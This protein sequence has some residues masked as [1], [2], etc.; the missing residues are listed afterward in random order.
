MKVGDV[1]FRKYRTQQNPSPTRE[2]KDWT[3]IVISLFEKKVW[4]TQELGPIVNWD[5]IDSE[6]HA[7]VLINERVVS[8]PLAELE[9][10]NEDR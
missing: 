6:P 7:D 8:I 2:H 4:R 1:V 5:R 3:G 10:F 9:L